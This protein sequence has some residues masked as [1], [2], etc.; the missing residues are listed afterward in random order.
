MGMDVFEPVLLTQL[1]DD[2]LVGV[3][4]HRENVIDALRCNR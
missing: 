3:T 1:Y 4:H 2:V